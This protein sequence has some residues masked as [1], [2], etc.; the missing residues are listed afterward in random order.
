MRRGHWKLSHWVLVE[1]PRWNFWGQY[2]PSYH[3]RAVAVFV[4]DEVYLIEQ[5]ARRIRA[6]KQKVDAQIALI[7]STIELVHKRCYL[8]QVAVLS[9]NRD[10]DRVAS[11]ADLPRALAR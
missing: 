5:E 3:W 2:R 10:A 6:L 9:G 8:S 7:D 1:V 11:A 4:D